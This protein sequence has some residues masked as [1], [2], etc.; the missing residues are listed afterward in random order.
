MSLEI[1]NIDETGLMYNAQ[2]RESIPLI[3]G[4]MEQLEMLRQEAKKM[5]E[6]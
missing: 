3:L 1:Y 5:R 4:S 2:V 6:D